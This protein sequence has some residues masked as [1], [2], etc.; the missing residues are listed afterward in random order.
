MIDLRQPVMDVRP[1][2]QEHAS[3]LV[4]K[5]GRGRREMRLQQ[6][7]GDLRPEPGQATIRHPH[8]SGTEEGRGAQIG[9]WIRKEAH[10]RRQILDLVS[11][12]ES[13]P[14]VDVGRDPAKLQL[15]LE[16]T[17]TGA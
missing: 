10:Q 6:S 5:R 11:V 1:N 9:P 7:R 14:L 3:I 16:L 8:E 12:E 4:R 17:M 2:V 13:E 15:V